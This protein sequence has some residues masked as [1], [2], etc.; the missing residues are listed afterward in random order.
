MAE[1]TLRTDGDHAPKF[2]EIPGG[3]ATGQK[4]FM[5]KTLSEDEALTSPGVP[6]RG[7]GY[8]MALYPWL[9]C[10][11]RSI[12]YHCGGGPEGTLLVVC[13][14]RT[15]TFGQAPP[16]LPGQKY[17]ID[18]AIEEQQVNVKYDLIGGVTAKINNGDGA[19]RRIGL[20]VYTIVADYGPAAFTPTLRKLIQKYT[21]EMPLNSVAFDLPGMPVSGATVDV[22][23]RHGKYLG[24]MI[25]EISASG[26]TP[27][28][29]R[30][31]HRVAVAGASGS[32]FEPWQNVWQMEAPN[33]TPGA[34]AIIGAWA[35]VQANISALF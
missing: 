2:D 10:V 14:Y 23:L 28:V 8:G 26:S 11:S 27:A 24:G 1:V 22:P 16:P 3:G 25:Q 33:G 18:M 4:V 21:F 6:Q 12:R 34:G 9:R 32:A 31:T 15:P 5:V 35:D 19:T 30:V 20:P 17:T 7:D 29:I 13:D